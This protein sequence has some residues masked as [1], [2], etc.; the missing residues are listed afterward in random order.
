MPASTETA[1]TNASLTRFLDA[2]RES[3]TLRP[4]EAR[5][6]LPGDLHSTR[7]LSGTVLVLRFTSCDL[8]E[9]EKTG[10]LTRHPHPAEV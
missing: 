2:A 1:M 6:Y 4:G 3:Y 5:V 9:E 10:R 7:Y 8:A